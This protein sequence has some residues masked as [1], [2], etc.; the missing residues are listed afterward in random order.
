MAEIQIRTKDMHEEAEYGVTAHVIYDES[1][2]PKNG[3]KH[4]KK[5]AW[6]KDLLEL[7]HK[8]DGSEE[9]LTRLKKDFFADRIFVF[10]PKGDVIELPSGATP[11]DFAYAIHS[12][13]GEHASGAKVNSKMVSLNTPL[14]THDVIEIEVKRA[15]RPSPKWL[16]FIKTGMARKHIKTFLTREAEKTKDDRPKK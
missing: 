5:T 12:E 11:I 6:I 3:G 2:K 1:G 7:H 16:S 15:G 8:I 13:I 4:E 9:F 10:T 14:K